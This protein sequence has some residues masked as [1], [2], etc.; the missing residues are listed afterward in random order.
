MPASITWHVADVTAAATADGVTTGSVWLVLDGT[1][2]PESGWWD[3][4]VSVLSTAVHSY[5]Q[6]IDGPVDEELADDE[7]E[8]SSYFFEGSYYLAYRRVEG[9][10]AKVYLEANCD[11]DEDNPVSIAVGPV[12][13]TDLRDALA[14]AVDELLGALEGE[15]HAGEDV[16]ILRGKKADLAA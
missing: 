10:T 8:T 3:L 2:F 9:D 7:A 1:A 16:A 14:R 13:L 15:P 11:K 4:P 6:L 5:R 12:L